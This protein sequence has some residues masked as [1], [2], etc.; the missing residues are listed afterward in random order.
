MRWG[1]HR[2]RLRQRLLPFAGR[3]ARREAIFRALTWGTSLTLAFGLLAASPTV[4]FAVRE[5]V[6]L[7]RTAL[8]RPFVE[9][10]ERPVPEGVWRARRERGIAETRG[11]LARYYAGAGPKMRRL[12]EV[13]GMDPEHAVVRWGNVDRTFCLSSGVFAP[14]EA[15][16][17]RLLPERRSIWLREIV[18]HRGPF[19]LFMVPDTA[20]VRAAAKEVGAVPVEGSAQTTNSWGLRGREPDPGAEVRGVVLGDSYMQGMFIGDMETP[21]SRLEA[22]LARSLGRSVSLL[23]GGHLGY[24]PEQYYRTLEEYGDRFR[25]GFAVVAVCSND[26]GD[27]VR[28]LEEGTADWE[29]A[30]YWLRR[31]VRY[32]RARMMNCVVA[33]VPD[34]RQ[35]L[36]TRRSGRFP[37]PL[38]RLVGVPSVRFVNPTDALATAHLEAV[39][40]L[41]ESGRQIQSY[42][43]MYNGHI[44]D[45]H[46]SPEGAEVWARETAR[47]L[48]ALGVDSAQ[49]Q[50]P[51]GISPPPDEERASAPA[52]RAPPRADASGGRPRDRS[53]G[54]PTR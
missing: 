39:R 46:F 36:A 6:S 19:G 23:N 37:G 27:G 5:G 51:G 25:P 47:R 34:E 30:G 12:F 4:R 40:R 48:L 17:Y 50:P 20:E 28:L 13:A 29:E 38:D 52:G 41:V 24:S 31:I 35:I 26:F 11:V 54:S 43:P 8:H 7:V 1:T 49:Y 33:V 18:L 14:D 45:G 16:S 22:E 42:S 44:G 9:A 21:P 2:A 15:R 53:P 3:L 32:C 10:D